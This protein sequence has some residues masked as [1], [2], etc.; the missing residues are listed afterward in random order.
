MT[1]IAGTEEEVDQ[2]MALAGTAA[3]E[4]LLRSGA[5]SSVMGS[6][7]F[8]GAAL[9]MLGGLGG[10][11]T[12]VAAGLTVVSPATGQPLASG[13]G[14]VSRTSISFRGNS[15]QWGRDMAGT[16][17]YADSKNGR[18]LTEAYI[19]AFN[20]LIAQQAALQAA[21]QP[22]A[23]A[24][25][26]A[27]PEAP[28]AIAAIDTAMRAGPSAEAEQ[29]RSLRAGT[30]LTPTGNRDGLWLEVED[31]FGTLGWVSVEDLQ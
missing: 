11:R 14:V 19:I 28:A 31:N 12:K 26:A 24:A 23:A 17:G 9:G 25:A 16:T 30:E 4:A 3:T 1:A 7:P 6:V 27:E 21:P 20:Q 29:V 18:R 5:A 22:G 10:R 2:G 13:S 8:G 15:G